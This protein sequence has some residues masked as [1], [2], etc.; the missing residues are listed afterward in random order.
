M[1]PRNVGS[2][3][4]GL[5]VHDRPVLCDQAER[6]K[7]TGAW[8]E[9]VN[10]MYPHWYGVD[11]QDQKTVSN[12]VKTEQPVQ[13]HCKKRML[14]DKQSALSPKA[15][16][17]PYYKELQFLLKTPELRQIKGNISPTSN[18]NIES[19]EE[20]EAESDTYQSYASDS[21]P[22]EG[23]TSSAASSEESIP[24]HQ[25]SMALIDSRPAAHGDS[26]IHTHGLRRADRQRETIQTMAEEA[27]ALIRRL[28]SRDQWDYFCAAIAEGIRKLPHDRQTPCATVIFGVLDIFTRA[29]C[30]LNLSDFL[31]TIYD[32]AQGHPPVSPY[33]LR[34]RNSSQQTNSHPTSSYPM[35]SAPAPHS[36]SSFEHPSNFISSVH[37]PLSTDSSAQYNFLGNLASPSNAVGYTT[38][39]TT[40]PNQSHQ[41]PPQF[42]TF[43]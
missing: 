32:A 42:H 33:D 24:D 36:T 12:N 4:T 40:Y 34:V 8:V 2:E 5:R 30:P 22:V 19:Q 1:E 9:V 26:A 14:E 17:C 41:S 31:R 29:Q 3:D 21:Q 25:Q 28:N 10:L 38:A 18:G 16:K 11:T 43:H 37:F 7:R 13:D 39:T 27:L 20:T 6:N 15:K 35:C 23:D